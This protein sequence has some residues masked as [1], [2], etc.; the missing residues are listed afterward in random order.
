[1]TRFRVPQQGHH[2]PY[3]PTKEL[4]AVR[5]SAPEWPTHGMAVTVSETFRKSLRLERTSSA[6]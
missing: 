1:M 3:H 5:D 4:M 2:V 6:M